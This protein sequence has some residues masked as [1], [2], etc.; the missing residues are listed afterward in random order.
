MRTL[1]IAV[2]LSAGLSAQVQPVADMARRVLA[3]TGSAPRECGRHL[4]RQ[5]GGKTVDAPLADLQASLQCVRQAI[6]AGEPVWAFVQRRGIDSF[7]AHG[8]LRT[9]N[10]DVQ[11]FYYDSAPCGG[12][13][14]EGELRLEPC[15]SPSVTPTSANGQAPDFACRQP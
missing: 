7:V 1:L 12:P 5:V 8:L 2:M 15:V 4:L 3:V 9:A 13:R 14:C 6:A 11:A 10:G